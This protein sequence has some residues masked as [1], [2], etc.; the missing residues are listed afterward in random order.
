[1]GLD[2]KTYWL[3]DWPSVAMW[4]WLWLWLWRWLWLWLRAACLLVRYPATDICEPH[5][6]HLFLYCCIHSAL[7]RN[8]SYPIVACVFLVKNACLLIRSLAMEPYVTIYL[9]KKFVILHRTLKVC[10]YLLTHKT[11][12]CLHSDVFQLVESQ[13]NWNWYEEKLW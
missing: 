1:M 6:K 8:G 12:L 11:I 7:H 4:L 3:T 2:T 13:M 10:F 9:H 5:R